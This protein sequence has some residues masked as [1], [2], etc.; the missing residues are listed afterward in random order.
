MRIIA[1]RKTHTH[2][3]YGFKKQ[4]TFIIQKEPNGT[5]VFYLRVRKKIKS[6]IYLQK[7]LYT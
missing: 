5:F 3:S 2:V 4:F 1:Q 7:E 6:N